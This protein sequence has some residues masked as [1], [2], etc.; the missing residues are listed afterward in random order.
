MNSTQRLSIAIKIC[1]ISTFK[2]LSKKHKIILLDHSL[3]CDKE[4]QIGKS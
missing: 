2:S 4:Q 1:I 3:H